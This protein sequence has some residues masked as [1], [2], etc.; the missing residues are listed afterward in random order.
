MAWNRSHWRF[1]NGVLV[2]LVLACIGA[3]AY[4]QRSSDWIPLACAVLG[5]LVLARAA[6]HMG[7]AA[8][9]GASRTYRSSHDRE[10]D[11]IGLKVFYTA[12]GRRL[13]GLRVVHVQTYHAEINRVTAYLLPAVLGARKRGAE[14]AQL[15]AVSSLGKDSLVKKLASLDDREKSLIRDAVGIEALRLFYTSG[16]NSG[17]EAEEH[18]AVIDGRHVILQEPHVHGTTNGTDFVYR[19]NWSKEA[20][21][22]EALFSELQKSS[23]ELA[24]AEI[25]AALGNGPF[26]GASC[27]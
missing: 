14:E 22:K 25:C 2:F 18:F 11:A 3:V 10:R 26:I 17:I 21:A 5:S 1:P 9:Y 12:L 27:S 6:L 7:F 20:R 19:E 15:I 13:E 4:W 23:I 16:A 8:P 24:A